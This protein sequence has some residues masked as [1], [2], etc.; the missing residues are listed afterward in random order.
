MQPRGALWNEALKPSGL[1]RSTANPTIHRWFAASILVLM[2][3]GGLTVGLVLQA[4]PLETTGALSSPT[5]STQPG[6]GWGPLAVV[7]PQEGADSGRAEGILRIADACT[8]LE[9]RGVGGDLMLLVWPADR[10]KWSLEG[11]AVAF[12]NYDGSTSTA[13]D[14][15]H[16]VLGGGGDSEEESGVSGDEWVAQT[17]WVAPPSDSCLL[18]SRW[19]V[20]DMKR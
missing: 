8:Y 9:S 17:S 4:R 14:G 7:G 19:Y 15:D 1:G 11:R 18:G 13:R 2:V 5:T 16:V 12:R 20:G 6:D 3:L 10:T